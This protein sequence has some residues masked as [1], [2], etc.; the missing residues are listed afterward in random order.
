MFLLTL[1]FSCSSVARA[2]S[3]VRVIVENATSTISSDHEPTFLVTVTNQSDHPLHVI[4]GARD[5]SLQRWYYRARVR[6][7]GH[8]VFLPRGCDLPVPP[9]EDDYVLLQSHAQYSFTL[10]NFSGTFDELK[11]GSYRVWIEYWCFRSGEE[12]Y[13]PDSNDVTLKVARRTVVTI[14]RGTPPTTFAAPN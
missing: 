13:P 6:Q 11:P 4:A 5:G 2:A 12:S 10:S 8:E 7:S 3:P 9:S 14:T 1:A